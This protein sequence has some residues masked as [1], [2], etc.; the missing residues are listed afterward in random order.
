MGDYFK[1]WLSMGEGRD[2]TKLPKVFHV[3]WFRK[4][5]AGKFIWPGFGENLRVLEWI[6]DRAEQDEKSNKN[7]VMTPIGWVPSQGSIDIKGLRGVTSETMDNLL[8]IDTAEWKQEVVRSR[9]FFKTLGDR[10]P[11]GLEAEVTRLEVLH[12]IDH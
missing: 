5:A 9:G 1:H 12:H 11:A 3:N 7:A 6:F 10:F 8:K 2:A 4:T